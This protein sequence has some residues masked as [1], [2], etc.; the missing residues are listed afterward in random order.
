MRKGTPRIATLGRTFAMLEAV[1][2]DGGQSNVSALARKLGVPVATAHRQIATLV[3]EGYLVRAGP[4]HVAGPR[5]LGLS[6]TIDEKQVIASIAAP[7]LKV[8]ASEIGGTVQLGTF[9]ND[10]VTYRIKAGKGASGLFTRVGMQLEAYSSAIGKVLLAFLPAPE[11]AAYLAGGPFVAM[12]GRTIVDPAALSRELDDTAHRGHAID[13][14]EV[15]DDLVCLAVPIRAPDGS[16]P[17]AISVSRF[18]PEPSPGDRAAIV[19]R[20]QDAATQI[21]RAVYGS[22]EQNRT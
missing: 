13:D 6:R 4:G 3:E 15:V 8:L 22:G 20:L 12:T 7:V 18:S 1:V 2:A 17:A 21:E 14:R 11:R 10:M 5:L 9:E 19:S 16:V